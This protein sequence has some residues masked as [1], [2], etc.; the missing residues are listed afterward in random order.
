MLKTIKLL[1]IAALIPFAATQFILAPARINPPLVEG[2]AIED[3]ISVTP[4]V[5][6]VLQRSCMDCH[7]NKTDWPFYS[8]VAPVSWY[9]VDHVNEGRREM[10]FSEWARYDADEAAHLLN[11]I[12]RTTRGGS[13]PMN[14]YTLLHRSAKLSRVDVEMLCV[15]SREQGRRLA[16]AG[17]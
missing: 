12:C 6:A 8:N 13:M 5:A 10:N 1:L 3:H 4:E 2:S 15:W 11:N 14:S 16:S 9:V 17:D 7:S